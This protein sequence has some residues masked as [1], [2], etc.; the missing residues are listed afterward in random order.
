MNNINPK[1]I[2][3]GICI[4]CHKDASETSFLKRPHTITK[5]LGNKKIGRDICDQC[6]EF[7]GNKDKNK[8]KGLSIEVCVK[9]V[10]NLSRVMLLDEPKIHYSSEFF[11]F[12]PIQHKIVVYPKFNNDQIWFD[13]FTRLFKRGIYEMWLQEYH[14]YNFDALNPLFDDIRDFARYDKGEIPL[15]YLIPCGAFCTHKSSLKNTS[16]HINENSIEDVYKYGFYKLYI[17]GHVFLLEV[18]P[19]AIE[20]REFY[21]DK[22]RNDLCIPGIAYKE[23][24]E[25]KSIKQIDIF[26]SSLYNSETISDNIKFLN[27]LYESRFQKKC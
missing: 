8:Y 6:N 12:D 22:I 5:A 14:S 26:L 25:L 23:M 24:I 7:F 21:F 11:K 4:F 27:S 3:D 9:E 19:K 1:F 15:Y 13:Q 20:N 2:H 18:T 10:L 17:A 16:F